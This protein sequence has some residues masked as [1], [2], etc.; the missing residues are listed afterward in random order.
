MKLGM[1][2][3]LLLEAKTVTSQLTPGDA[4]KQF[5]V[6]AGGSSQIAL[7]SLDKPRNDGVTALVQAVLNGHREVV[8]RHSNGW[9]S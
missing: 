3:Q 8:K 7:K 5:T 1:C 6:T 4:D 2:L 9:S